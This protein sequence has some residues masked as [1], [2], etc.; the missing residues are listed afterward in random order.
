M[1]LQPVSYIGV[2]R[3]HFQYSIPSTKLLKV[4]NLGLQPIKC[5]TLS[6][7]ILHGT[8]RDVTH[9]P[10]FSL[11]LPILTRRGA[12][13]SDTVMNGISIQIRWLPMPTTNHVWWY[14]I[15]CVWLLS[16]VGLSNGRSQWSKAWVRIPPGA[17]MSVSCK[18]CVLSDR[19][20]FVGLIT[21]P[22]GSYR[23]LCVWVWSW[24]LHNEETLAH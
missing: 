20:L 16:E 14:F 9:C 19:G 21:R 6:L 12:T 22:E 5:V 15:N 8:C 24:S 11:S 2:C 18:C 1:E 10:F 13:G 7:F 3:P 4:C 23:V 17:W